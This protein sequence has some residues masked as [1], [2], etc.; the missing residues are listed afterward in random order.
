ML[1]FYL[2]MALPS[3]EAGFY[4]YGFKEETD[5]ITIP[6]ESLPLFR[7]DGPFCLTHRLIF[8]HRLSREPRFLGRIGCRLSPCRFPEVDPL[9]PSHSL[10]FGFGGALSRVLPFSISEQE[11][12]YERRLRRINLFIV[13]RAGACYSCSAEIPSWFRISPMV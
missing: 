10:R 8:L 5:P 2:L 9:R 13:L 7:L 3:V 6:E 4:E 1:S 12:G 11:K